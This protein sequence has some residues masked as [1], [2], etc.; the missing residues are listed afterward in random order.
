MK[1][2]DVV[3]GQSQNLHSGKDEDSA[4]TGRGELELGMSSTE[5]NRELIPET[6]ML[7]GSTCY[8]PNQSSKP[9][10]RRT[11]RTPNQTLIVQLPSTGR[12]KRLWVIVSGRIR[13]SC[14][15]EM[16]LQG[17]GEVTEGA[18]FYCRYSITIDV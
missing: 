4:V 6:R 15:L 9:R 11:S 18:R 13:N 17:A 14:R 16:N 1:G 8:S 2:G 10:N 7:E 12:R 3:F 5:R